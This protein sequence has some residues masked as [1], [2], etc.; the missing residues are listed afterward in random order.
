MGYVAVG[1]VKFILT[2]LLSQGRY[3]AARAVYRAA[4]TAGL[5]AFAA[6]ATGT[7][8]AP[9]PEA[10][11]IRAAVYAAGIEAQR[12]DA[13][14]GGGEA[15]DAAAHVFSRAGELALYHTHLNTFLIALEKVLNGL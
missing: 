4:R 6:A 10:P 8:A 11:F 9:L 13:A 12:Q 3:N 1:E 15:A 14:G 2:Y 7:A 5:A